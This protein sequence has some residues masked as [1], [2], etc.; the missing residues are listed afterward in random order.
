[1][2]KGRSGRVRKISPPPGFDPQTV[3]PVVSR[4]TTELPGPS[5]NNMYAYKITIQTKFHESG[6]SLATDDN[7]FPTIT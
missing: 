5:L 7:F 6:K 1:V 4:Y 2:S 3:Q